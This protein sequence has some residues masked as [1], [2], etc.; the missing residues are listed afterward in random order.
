MRE[1][2]AVRFGLTLAIGAV[3]AAIALSGATAQ[4]LGPP[5]SPAPAPGSTWLVPGQSPVWPASGSPSGT[6]EFGVAAAASGGAW[7][8]LMWPSMTG[9]S[10]D[11]LA[12]ASGE[13]LRGPDGQPLFVG[14]YGDADG[15][16]DRF[17]DTIIAHDWPSAVRLKTGAFGFDVSPHAGLG[18]SE[19]G[20]SQ[21]AGALLRFGRGVGDAG[22]AA[23][24]KWFLFAST[25]QQSLGT[26]FT[27]NQDA[28]KRANLGRDPGATIADTRAGLAWRDGPI[29]A[30][31]GYLFRE[32]RPRDLDMLDAQSTRESL[33]S[34]RL[35]FHPGQR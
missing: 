27:F 2:T 23:R 20:G 34:F 4:P 14:R 18:L 26:G 33:V 28:W 10:I 1:L 13:P 7:R 12:I 6:N 30:S 5:Q 31:V 15:P 16:L 19:S 29:E 21:N 3:L 35:S 9:G 24:T 17:A 11:R 22:Q 25:D 32:I 8:G